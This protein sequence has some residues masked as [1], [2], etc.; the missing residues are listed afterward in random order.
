LLHSIVNQSLI[1]S[2][3]WDPYIFLSILFS[4]T[5]ILEIRGSQS[6]EIVS[7]GL[8]VCDDVWSYRLLPVFERNLSPLSSG[9]KSAVKGI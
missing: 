3:F 1:T 4:N 5:G 6:S 7:C 9:L 2:S 8:L